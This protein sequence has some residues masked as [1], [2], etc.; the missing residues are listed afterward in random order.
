ML[1]YGEILKAMKNIVE[2]I[3]E[4]NEND[5]TPKEYLTH[6]TDGRKL[7]EEVILFQSENKSILTNN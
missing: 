4:V 1:I 6:S 7:I 5:N 3:E 2:I